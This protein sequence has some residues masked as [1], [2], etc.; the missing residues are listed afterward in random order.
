MEIC[1]AS[2]VNTGK[3]KKENEKEG[4]LT[5]RFH[6][7]K[8]KT[9]FFHTETKNYAR[10]EQPCEQDIKKINKAKAKSALSHESC[11]QTH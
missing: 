9:G 8:G 5:V 2:N 6:I 3:T 11:S 4:S 1:T 7:S 10:R